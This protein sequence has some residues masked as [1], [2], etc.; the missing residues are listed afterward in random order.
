MTP[1]ARDVVENEARGPKP[2]VRVGCRSVQLCCCVLWWVAV[3]GCVLLVC[4]CVLLW[5]AVAVALLNGFVVCRLTVYADSAVPRGTAESEVPQGTDDSAFPR[6]G[7]RGTSDSGRHFRSWLMQ[8]ATKACRAPRWQ[9]SST[10]RWMLS[11]MS[12]RRGFETRGGGARDSAAG[13]SGGIG[14]GS[15]GQRGAA[16]GCGNACS[17]RQSHC[18]DEAIFEGAAA[19][20]SF[21]LRPGHQFGGLRKPREAEDKAKVRAS[22]RTNEGT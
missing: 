11:K 15:W 22:L 21:S 13:C 1:L 16:W 10:R 17:R 14:A 2:R 18:G 9:R 7:L 3:G 19:V 4:C 8:H 12:L 6:R 20:L 5:V